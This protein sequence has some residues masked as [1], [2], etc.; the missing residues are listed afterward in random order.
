M[1]CPPHG[2]RAGRVVGL[3]ARRRTPACLTTA[4]VQNDSMRWVLVICVGFVAALSGKAAAQSFQARPLTTTVTVPFRIDSQ[5]DVLRS[6]AFA[7]DDYAALLDWRVNIVANSWTR[8][9]RLR[10]PSTSR[11][12]S[13]DGCVETRFARADLPCTPMPNS[14]RDSL[15]YRWGTTLAWGTLYADQLNRTVSPLPL[16]LGSIPPYANASLQNPGTEF[17]FFSGPTVPFDTA[18]PWSGLT[19]GPP[20]HEDTGF[21]IDRIDLIP[22]SPPAQGDT[23]EPTTG[24]HRRV[25]GVLRGG[26]DGAEDKYEFWVSSAQPANLAIWGRN[27]SLGTTS[28]DDAFVGEVYVRCGAKPTTTANDYYRTFYQWTQNV[29]AFLRLREREDGSICTSGWYVTIVNATGLNFM[30]NVLVGRNYPSREW[31]NVRVGIEFPAGAEEQQWIRQALREAAWRIYGASGGS[32]VLHSYSID[33]PGSC[34]NVTV[35]WRNRPMGG[36]ACKNQTGVT[37][38]GTPIGTVHIC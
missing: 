17:R 14:D 16:Q 1:S 7:G 18:I 26:T 5:D 30:F 4:V 13:E 37:W 23:W 21:L 11:R 33:P 8:F 25:M 36:A 31:T 19:G 9:A 20:R 35:C 3:I 10:G 28:I 24:P 34:S 38:P 29:P 15:G 22:S 27:P 6:L 32:Q 12:L 2:G